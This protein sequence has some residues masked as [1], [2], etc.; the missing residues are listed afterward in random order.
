MTC[1]LALSISGVSSVE[2]LD[3]AT[4]DCD[5]GR[6]GALGGVVCVAQGRGGKKPVGDGVSRSV[7]LLSGIRLTQVGD[8][9]AHR[10]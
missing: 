3:H 8:P 4:D 1:W 6:V 10:Q 2:G 9:R 7:S 5:I